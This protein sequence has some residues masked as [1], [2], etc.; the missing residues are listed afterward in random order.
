MLVDI[1]NRQA[2]LGHDVSLLIINDGV[3]QRLVSTI[4]PAVTVTHWPR[5][6]G[7]EKLK[8][9]LRI[10]WWVRRQRPDAVHIHDPKLPGLLRGMDRKLLY[11]VHALNLS[12]HWMRPTVRQAAI[13]Q[14]VMDNALAQNPLANVCVVGNG[15][16]IDSLADRGNRPALSPFRIVQ[17]AR[18]NCVEKGQDILIKAL[19]VLRQRG[20]CDVTVDFIGAGAD[21]DMLRQLADGQGV[22]GQVN[23]RG[24][25]TRAEVYAAYASYD[26][27]VHPSRFEGFGLII[28]EAMGAGLPVAVP[29]G[30]GPYEVIGKGQFGEVFAPESPQSVA[31][32]IE[33]VRAGYPAALKRAETARAAAVARYSLQAQVDAYLRLYQGFLGDLRNL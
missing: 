25:L 27:M 6:P 32:A 26:L 3:D 24:L 23:F 13:S 5:K 22:A 11:T 9:A 30:G 29:E 2:Q 18:L 17:S 28:A 33:R 20:I 15:I 16:N 12:Q 7:S 21:L 10:N 4:N 19:G 14:A 1:M 8:L 31:D